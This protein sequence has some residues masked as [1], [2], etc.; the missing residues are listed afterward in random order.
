MR[1]LM[2][3]VSHRASKTLLPCLFHATF[4]NS[5]LLSTCMMAHL[6]TVTHRHVIMWG[7][8]AVKG[9]RGFLGEIILS[10]LSDWIQTR[11]SN[12]CICRESPLGP[13]LSCTPVIC[14]CIGAG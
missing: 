2:G 3:I 14:S 10:P 7:W 9:W 13:L 12:R 8:G 5:A 1:L 4:P 6:T 11:C